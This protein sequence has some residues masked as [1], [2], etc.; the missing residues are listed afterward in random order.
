MLRLEKKTITWIIPNPLV[1]CFHSQMLQN[2]NDKVTPAQSMWPLFC[3][4]VGLSYDQEERVRNFQKGLL[5]AKESWLERHTAYAS[6]LTIKSTHESLQAVGFRMGH[7]EAL[8]DGLLTSDQRARL[9]NFVTTQRASIK[10]RI[11]NKPSSFDGYYQTSP[12]QHR[13]GNLY[14]T[15]HRLKSVLHKIPPAAPLLIGLALKKLSR[16]PSFE[17]LGLVS[18]DKKENEEAELSRDRSFA[19]CGSLKRSASEMSMDGEERPHATTISPEEA[20]SVA[21]PYV[22]SVI[23]HLKPIIPVPTPAA[24][25]VIHQMPRAP[26]SVSSAPVL[27]QPAPAAPIVYTERVVVPAPVA[28]APQPPPHAPAA[29]PS[30]SVHIHVTAPIA[31][32]PPQEPA[33]KHQRKS[34]FLPAGLNV[35]PEEMWPADSVAEEFLMSLVD[36]DWAIGEGVDMEI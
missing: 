2:G 29:V 21:I 34:S 17:S 16:R 30:A 35:V 15:N 23:G 3:N 24:P 25:A 6:S 36:G 31:P 11:G 18:G 28:S 1:A 13:S 9:V 12:E 32:Q 7:R 8:V 5:A 27:A 33:S 26:R 4:E 10:E 22:E 20:E 19:S 14:V